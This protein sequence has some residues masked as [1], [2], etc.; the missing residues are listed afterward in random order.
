MH[1]QLMDRDK[2]WI[3]NGW[4]AKCLRSGSGTPS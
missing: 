1:N 3:M 2:Q 4:H